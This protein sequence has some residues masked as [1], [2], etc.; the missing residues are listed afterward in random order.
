MT[1]APATVLESRELFKTFG[2]VRA[3]SNVSMSLEQGEI[4]GLIGPNGAGKSTLVNLLS[5]LFR[6]DRGTVIFAGQDVTSM[7]PERRTRLGLLRT[8]QQLRAFRTFTVAQSLGAA[9]LAQRARSAQKGASSSAAIASTAERFGIASIMG[10][11]LS[12]LPYGTQ[13]IVNLALV[14]LND[15]QVLLLDEPF[16]G[17]EREDILRLSE[18]I[19]DF[20]ERG[21]GVCLV[22]HDMEAVMQT[23]RRILVLDAGALIFDGTPVAARTNQLVRR[24]YLGNREPGAPKAAGDRP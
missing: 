19:R 17:V 24:V 15:P 16:A 2:G 14:S 22:E 10:R 13:K 18:I 6:P 23:C 9:S 1:S 4:L 3:V 21:V 20:A 11:L 5:G 12:E 7:G 8:F